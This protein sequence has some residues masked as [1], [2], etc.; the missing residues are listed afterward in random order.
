[1]AI[2]QLKPLRVLSLA[3]KIYHLYWSVRKIGF[4][5]HTITIDFETTYRRSP[6][7]NS[8][9]VIEACCLCL[10]L[11][12]SYIFAIRSPVYGHLR[13]KP[14][15]TCANRNT[16]RP[17]FS[18]TGH[19]PI[20]RPTRSDQ[21]LRSS[22]HERR[23]EKHD[24]V[25]HVTLKLQNLL[26]PQLLQQTSLLILLHVFKVKQL[27]WLSFLIFPSDRLGILVYH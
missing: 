2:F 25:F 19:P 26:L 6:D 9:F 15:N 13:T 27:L 12:H 21:I 20:L 5:L 24:F 23:L 17:F 14:M 10:R 22:K 1:M 18:V 3:E 7:T 16:Y 11:D 4:C 8:I